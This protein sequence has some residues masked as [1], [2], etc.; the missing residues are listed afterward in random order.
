LLPARI[1]SFSLGNPAGGRTAF[2]AFIIRAKIKIGINPKKRFRS[3]R[4]RI[5][6]LYWNIVITSIV[7]S[8]FKC[9]SAFYIP[10]SA[11]GIEY[12]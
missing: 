2:H 1:I 12:I 9:E 3:G 10:G 6:I 4:K 8:P 5:A 7:K 11:I